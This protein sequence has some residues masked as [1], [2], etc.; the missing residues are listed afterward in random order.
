MFVTVWE[1]EVR[2]GMEAA[3]E[4]LYGEHGAG[5]GCSGS[6]PATCAP[7]CCEANATVIT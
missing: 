6:N 2:L 7:I 3:F 4:Q 5:C 1:Y